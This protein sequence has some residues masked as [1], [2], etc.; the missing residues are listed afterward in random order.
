MQHRAIVDK[1]Q[2]RPRWSV[3]LRALREARGV[4]LDGWAA[5]FEVGRTTVQRWERG[6]TA[7]TAAVEVALI[8]YCHEAALFRTY[9][10]GPLTG[11]TLTPSLLSDLLAEARWRSPGSEPPAPAPAPAAT[12]GAVPSLSPSNLPA[13]LT[14]FIG[15]EAELAAARRAQADA[16]LF[17]FTGAGGCGK[18]RLALALA[19]ELRRT[20]TDGVWWV[21]LTPLTDP[22]LT[23][24]TVAAAAGISTRSAQPLIDVL[25]EALR[26]RH[27]LLV[28]DNC[29]HVLSTCAALVESLLHACPRLAIITTSREWL[30]VAGESVFRVPPLTLP[31]DASTLMQSDA[32][33]LFF[34][35]V[36]RT[37][38]AAAL[39]AHDAEAVLAICR[40]VDG[41][42]LALEL[43][44]ARAKVLSF[45][46]IAE[47]LSDRFRLLTGGGRTARPRHQTLRAAIDWSYDLLTPSE[48]A[49]FTMVSVFAG[50]FSLDA[51]EWLLSGDW[52]GSGVSAADEHTDALT[53]IE[54]L[55]EKSLVIADAGGETARYRMLE[56]VRQYAAERLA[57][58]GVT[59][60]ARLR[61]AVWCVQLGEAVWPHRSGPNQSTWL[62]RLA[63]EHDNLRTALGWLTSTAG[64]TQHAV[65]LAGA[66]WWF[67]ETR[68]HIS[69]GRRWLAAVLALPGDAAPA[70]RARALEGAGMLARLQGDL[71]VA[72]A[73]HE[74]SL[75]MRRELGDDAGAASALNNLGIAVELSGD[76]IH[77]RA[78]YEECLAYGRR[79]NDPVRIIAPLINLGILARQAGDPAQALAHYAEAL[80]VARETGDIR[81]QA[82]LL[83][84]MG[85][86][87]E[88]R[89]DFAEA[90]TCIHEALRLFRDLADPTA[91]AR[92][93]TSLAALA[94]DLGAAMRA[95]RHSAAAA[96]LRSKLGVRLDGQGQQRF[97]KDVALA[98]AALGDVRF[99]AAW[100]AGQALS[101]DDVITEA[102][103]S[104]I[105]TWDRS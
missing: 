18:T 70:D 44:A 9:T 91:I 42:P 90:V 4:T 89:R 41:I 34:D 88:E 74:Q 54:R 1:S 27:T 77:A 35:R 68:G 49:A 102:L 43:A 104:M 22:A 72:R 80:A 73:M 24:D 40:S 85:N 37:V 98:R 2:A 58:H 14:S 55:V 51:A 19:E 78:L 101:L 81:R 16:R 15:R 95:A 45:A 11:V 84:N 57:E 6:D 46:Q 83:L 71:V 29:E 64:Y 105:V 66:L 53:L 38:P 36:Q 63:V 96:A 92:C 65:R 99:A 59:D 21:D 69:E 52:P 17:T 25:I 10:S 32:A 12:P 5:R 56:T 47:R 26:G 79:M 87:H 93:L 76:R 23:P 82:T 7:P 97:D 94:N 31:E 62:T 100:E 61:Q 75:A 20:Y 67:W 86:A 39:T 60:T 50:G 48:Q 103:A 8:E 33:R 3:T 28:L 13:L 30:G